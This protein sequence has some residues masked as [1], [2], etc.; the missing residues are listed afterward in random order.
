MDQNLVLWHSRGV[1][2][3]NKLKIDV[4]ETVDSLAWF[5]VE[6]DMLGKGSIV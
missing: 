1:E 2:L 6:G 5:N 3:V 4:L